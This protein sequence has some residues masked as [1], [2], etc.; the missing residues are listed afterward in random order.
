MYQPN[1]QDWRLC[2]SKD[3]IAV[4]N[5]NSERLENCIFKLEELQE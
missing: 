1:N 4:I 3:L 2:M 5:R